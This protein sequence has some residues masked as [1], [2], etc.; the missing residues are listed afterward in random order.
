MII[1]AIA[2][3]CC[4]L[5]DEL[6]EAP[7]R[8]LLEGAAT[9]TRVDGPL[10]CVPGQAGTSASVLKPDLHFGKSSPTVDSLDAYNAMVSGGG[11]SEVSERLGDME[12]NTETCPICC[13]MIIL[14]PQQARRDAPAHTSRTLLH[15]CRPRSQAI[16]RLFVPE[17][18]L[19][20]HFACGHALHADCYA[21]YTCSKRQCPVCAVDGSEVPREYMSPALRRQ[22]EAT[23]APQPPEPHADEASEYDTEEEEY[24]AEEYAAEEE[25]ASGWDGAGPADHDEVV[26]VEMLQAARAR[27]RA[28]SA[29]PQRRRRQLRSRE[30]AC[31]LGRRWSGKRSE[32]C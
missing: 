28:A 10:Q 11:A 13:E 29:H 2:R 15:A 8:A 31:A 6:P 3:C 9:S 17:G 19:P 14:G 4:C 24:A 22:A 5:D 27:R 21:I 12:L 20:R 7:S 25:D 18:E 26:D 32:T 30:A 1:R 23:H 16:E